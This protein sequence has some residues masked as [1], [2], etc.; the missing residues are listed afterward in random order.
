[1]KVVGAPVRFGVLYFGLMAY[2]TAPGHAFSRSQF[3]AIAL[4][5]LV[6]LSLLAL[7]GGF[8]RTVCDHQCRR[9][10]RWPLVDLHRRALSAP[11]PRNR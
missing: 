1:M 7:L 9:G 4:A 2:A 6:R 10:H 5:P 11:R 3:V 8:S